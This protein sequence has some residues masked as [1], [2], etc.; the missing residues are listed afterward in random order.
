MVTPFKCK[1]IIWGKGV[2]NSAIQDLG[3]IITKHKE[4]C[5]HMIQ[6]QILYG[7]VSHR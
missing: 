1:M 7:T 6:A 4:Q 3:S 5:A 2:L